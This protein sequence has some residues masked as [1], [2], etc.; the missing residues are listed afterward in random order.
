MYSTGPRLL[1]HT[2]TLARGPLQ[3]PSKLACWQIVL[4]QWTGMTVK[5]TN[6][7]LWSTISRF[8][9]R[10]FLLGPQVPAPPVMSL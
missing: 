7:Q 5:T 9:C 4:E 10:N 3:A 6:S 8:V 1:A 2:V